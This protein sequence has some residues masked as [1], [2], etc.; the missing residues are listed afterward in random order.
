MIQ[1]TSPFY[2]ACSEV[3]FPTVSEASLEFFS[4]IHFFT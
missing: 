4:T 3:R 1:L 2:F